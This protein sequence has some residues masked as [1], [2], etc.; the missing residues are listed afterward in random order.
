MALSIA[1]ATQWDDA[2]G[3]CVFDCRPEE[4]KAA[5]AAFATFARQ[6]GV[7]LLSEGSTDAL[8]KP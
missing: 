4:L 2:G 8:V 1:E 3:H 6:H 7:R 5:M